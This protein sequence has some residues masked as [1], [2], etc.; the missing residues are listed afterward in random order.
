MQDSEKYAAF[1]I[2]QR[3]TQISNE[4]SSSADTAP[5]GGA[6][7]ED[8]RFAEVEIDAGM[9]RESAG[10]SALRFYSSVTPAQPIEQRA[11]DPL[12]QKFYEM[13][14]LA[15][16]KPFSRNDSDLF[17]R[18]AKFMEKYVDDYDGDAKFVMYFP[19]YQH[20]SAEQLRTYFS[21]RA[22]VRRG[23]IEPVS[24]SYAYVYVY[25]L[26]SGIGV[27]DPLDGLGKLVTIWDDFLK[28]GPALEN[29]MPRWFKDYH[30]YYGLSH[31]FEEFV[32]EHDLHRYYSLTLILDTDEEKKLELWNSLS[33]YD[34]TK[35][36]FYKGGNEQLLQDCFATVLTRLREFYE[37]REA[38]FENILIY[39]VSNKTPWYPFRQALFYDWFK[40]PDHKVIM[41]GR[42]RYYCQN[43]RWTASL[44]IY[45][46]TQK[47]FIGYIIK[48][49]ESC[50]RK[51]VKYKHTLTTEVRTGNKVFSELRELDASPSEL[52]DV[53]ENAVT[54]FHRDINRTIVTVDHANLARIRRE[55][56]GTTEKLI[57]PEEVVNSEFL[58]PNSELSEQIHD[59]WVAFKAA[60]SPVELKALTIALTDS[61]GV[62]AF[63]DENGIMLEVLTDSI[64]EKAADYI[65]DNI[66]EVD[67]GI[68]IYDEY[69]ETI[70]EMVG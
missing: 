68:I 20:M 7:L 3:V 51:V 13:R 4:K 6:P 53:I 58:I 32:K 60:L 9:R 27:T 17:Y 2:P 49:T 44:P 40:Q 54:D 43:N 18:Q 1:L 56:I 55:A 66:I 11:S 41:P 65:G 8:T 30:V 39:R 26:L 63:A 19:Y 23:I 25:E 57:V 29:H 16:S 28:Y 42:E 46:S 67:D 14:K 12:R 62:K 69:R 15:S 45:Y 50:L 38:R 10:E 36:K 48:K 47:D 31:S 5:A 24:V 35:S 22:K 33:A 52:D 34:V 64:N 70:A 59:G 61:A 37:S 21:W